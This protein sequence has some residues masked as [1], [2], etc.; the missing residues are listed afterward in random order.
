MSFCGEFK[1]NRDIFLDEIFRDGNLSLYEDSMPQTKI[2]RKLFGHAWTCPNSFMCTIF[3]SE[4]MHSVE[5]YCLDNMLFHEL[6]K[7]QVIKIYTF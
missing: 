4:G 7:F 1:K 3:K 5:A 2:F 6:S